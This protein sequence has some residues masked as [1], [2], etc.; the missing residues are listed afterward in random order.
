MIELL[1]GLTAATKLPFGETATAEA[2]TV[3]LGGDEGT[4]S[5]FATEASEVVTES[6]DGS[7]GE[8]S[9]FTP[10][11]VDG[12]VGR[13]TGVIDE[14]HAISRMISNTGLNRSTLEI[15]PRPRFNPSSIRDMLSRWNR[16]AWNDSY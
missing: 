1:S 15:R 4:M 5:V 14:T 8:G 13:V 11:V 2:E 12:G 7:R 6:A 10:V 16:W 9:I 3:W